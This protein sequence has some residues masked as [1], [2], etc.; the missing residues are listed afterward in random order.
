M[1]RSVEKVIIISTQSVECTE[2]VDFRIT[3]FY[4]YPGDDILLCQ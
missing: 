2:E 3:S 4:S 1:Y